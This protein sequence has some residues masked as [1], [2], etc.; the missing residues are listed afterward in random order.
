MTLLVAAN[1][2]VPLTVIAM[3]GAIG[4]VHSTSGIVVLFL[5]APGA[6]VGF[7]EGNDALMWLRVVVFAAIQIAYY[8]VVALMIRAVYRP[9]RT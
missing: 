3:V 7:F 9:A 2:G 6:V 1:I 5:L 4:L 8:V